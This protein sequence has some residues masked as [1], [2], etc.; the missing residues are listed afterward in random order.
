MELNA[1]KFAEDPELTINPYFFPKILDIFFS[2]F[3]TFFPSIKDKLLFFKTL[4][5]AFISL[6]S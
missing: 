6:W 4:L 1:N 2:K 3:F 5:T